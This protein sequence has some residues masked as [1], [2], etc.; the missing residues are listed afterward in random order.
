MRGGNGHD[1][2]PSGSVEPVLTRQMFGLTTIHGTIMCIDRA[3][4]RVTHKPPILIDPA[5]LV[6]CTGLEQTEFGIFEGGAWRSVDIGL[7]GPSRATAPSRL[8]ATLIDGTA[9]FRSS[10][11]FVGLPPDGTVRMDGREA[12]S[13]EWLGVVEQ[14]ALADVIDMCRNDWMRVGDRTLVRKSCIRLEKR[15]D[16]RIDQAVYP[17]AG[18]FPLSTASG[19]RRNLLFREGW[20]VDEFIRFRPLVYFVLMGAG[21]YADQLELASRSLVDFGRYE[22]DLL[23]I[24]D[25]DRH[26][27]ERLIPDSLHDR[28]SVL[29]VAS[30]GKIDAVLARL[31]L[32]EHDGADQFAP[33]LYTD[34]DVIYDRPLQPILEAALLS[35]KM[36]AQSERWNELPGSDAAGGDLFAVDPVPFYDKIGFNAGIWIMPGGEDSIQIVNTIRLAVS[37][38]LEAH[39]RESLP[40][41]D[42]AMGNYVLRK[43]D[44]FDSALITSA[45]R[46]CQSYEALDTIGASGFVHFWPV[47]AVATQRAAAMADYL[48][49][50]KLSGATASTTTDIGPASEIVSSSPSRAQ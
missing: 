25:R 45:T 37:R 23:V 30:S 27:I 16:I 8:Q 1:R 5:D 17:I 47:S 24:T 18:N 50:L 22:G 11:G 26:F 20:I 42:Q 48:E 21:A 33:I 14:A 31:M 12:H 44:A 10:L 2:H 35:R 29:R 46:L 40:W 36:S 41:L 38:Y 28:L 4:R 3:E 49:R 39:G 15:T 34:T 19:R 9:T 6:L 32:G 43:L 13:W 7:G